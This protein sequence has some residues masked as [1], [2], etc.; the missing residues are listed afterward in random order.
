MRFVA[1][2]VV[3]RTSLISI[4]Y[5]P[6]RIALVRLM[7]GSHPQCSGSRELG[8]GAMSQMENMHA[9]IAVGIGLAGTIALWCLGMLVATGFWPG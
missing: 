6:R 3:R 9:L 4:K 8:E 5:L 1:V 7:V 2:G